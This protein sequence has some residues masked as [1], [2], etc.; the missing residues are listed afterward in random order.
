MFLHYFFYSFVISPSQCAPKGSTER[1][2]NTFSVAQ[3]VHSLLIALPASPP[4]IGFRF[5]QIISVLLVYLFYMS[6]SMSKHVLFLC[7]I[8]LPFLYPSVIPK[9][10]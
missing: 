3:P 6:L 2:T 9:A 7:F 1:S 8:H 5:E 4:L 10:Q